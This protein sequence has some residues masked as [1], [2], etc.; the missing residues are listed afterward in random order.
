MSKVKHSVGSQYK[1]GPKVGAM[2][3]RLPHKSRPHYFQHKGERYAAIRTET[4]G[5][6]PIYKRKDGWWVGHGTYGR[7]KRHRK[8]GFQRTMKNIV[9]AVRKGAGWAVKNS[10][11]LTKVAKMIA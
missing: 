10:G 5:E 6:R 7:G 3:K 4:P 2:I 1:P 11:N 8:Y 9:G